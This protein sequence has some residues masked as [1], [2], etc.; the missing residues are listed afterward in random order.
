[1][2]EPSHF[3]VED[4]D[5][6]HG[7]IRAYPLGVLA[8][9]GSAG[10]MA[11]PVPFILHDDLGPHGILRAHLA[12]PNP[13]WREIG[14]GADVLIVFQG[15]DH[16]I[17]PGWYASKQEHGKVVPTWNYVMVQVKGRARAIDDSVW[18]RAQL[19]SLTDAHE[20]PR[21]EPWSVS[22]APDNFIAAQMRGIV[23][24]EVEITDI[25]GKFKVSQNRQEADKRS[26][27]SGL[28]AQTES[29]AQAMAKLVEERGL[30][31]RP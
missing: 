2:Y 31:V 5:A 21:S 22:D 23:G 30:K 29:S 6:L 1:M 10:L 14:D 11:N 3:K 18:L 4:R 16:Y 15:V 25:A 26:V 13:Q 12:R 9:A 28:S 24:I 20:A 7:V 17:T 27:F 19:E 8:T